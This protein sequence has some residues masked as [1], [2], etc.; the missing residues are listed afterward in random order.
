MPVMNR[1]DLQKIVPV[2]NHIV[3]TEAGARSG[4]VTYINPNK[5]LAAPDGSYAV[6]L[7]NPGGGQEQVREGDGVH[8]TRAGAA[9]IAHQMLPLFDAE[10]HLVDPPPPPPPAPPPPPPPHHEGRQDQVAAG[11]LPERERPR[12]QLS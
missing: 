10:R 12:V 2:V 9:R 3:K 11:Q 1:A 4:K 5:V 6:Y 8:F 7:P